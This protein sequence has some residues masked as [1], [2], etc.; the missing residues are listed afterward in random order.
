MHTEQGFVEL[1][2]P[3]RGVVVPGNL[4]LEQAHQYAKAWP[5]VFQGTLGPLPKLVVAH[6]CGQVW[7]H[8]TSGVQPPLC[9]HLSASPAA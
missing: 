5:E 9:L 7:A 8:D 4:E 2:D 3:G 6:C 1:Q